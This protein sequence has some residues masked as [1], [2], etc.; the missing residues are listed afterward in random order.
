MTWTFVLDAHASSTFLNC[1]LSCN[2]NANCNAFQ[3]F[4]QLTWFCTLG[5]TKSTTLVSVHSIPSLTLIAQDHHSDTSSSRRRRNL[6]STRTMSNPPES[7]FDRRLPSLFFLTDRIICSHCS[8]VNMLFMSMTLS[9][10]RSLELR[11]L[12]FESRC[13]TASAKRFL[14]QLLALRRLPTAYHRHLTD[15]FLSPPGSALD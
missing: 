14:E 13:N 2:L 10:T 5:P 9:G 8:F 11:A 3:S 4:A 1:C 15:L 7:N 6:D 12:V